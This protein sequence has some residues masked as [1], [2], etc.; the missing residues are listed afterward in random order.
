MLK[1]SGTVTSAIFD[2]TSRWLA[3]LS[4]E[5]ARLWDL[6]A[7]DPSAHS[8][9]VLRTHGGSPTALTVGGGGRWVALASSGDKAARL[10]DLTSTET[11]ARSRPVRLSGHEAVIDAIFIERDGRRV[12]TVG[13]DGTARFWTIDPK[14]LG[15]RAASAVGRNLTWEEWS[16][17][18]PNRSSYECTFPDLP[19]P[20]EGATDRPR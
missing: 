9:A 2:S 20:L 4:G 1:S 13:V 11:E 8:E 18:F 7:D 3:T 12:V 10:W 5:E 6:S 16:T 15:R 17:F 14:E 19:C